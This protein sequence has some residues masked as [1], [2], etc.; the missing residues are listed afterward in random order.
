MKLHINHI[1]LI[2][3]LWGVLFS[4]KREEANLVFLP[5]SSLVIDGKS[6]VNKFNCVYNSKKLNDTLMI[7]YEKK[8]KKYL[9]N[10]AR[11][12]LSNDQFDCGGKGINRDFHKLLRTKEHPFIQMRLKSVF[13]F[14]NKD[15][16]VANI[17]YEIN[18]IKKSYSVPI[19]YSKKLNTIHISGEKKL[20]I[21]DFDLKPPKKLLGIIKV[22]ENIGI[23]FDFIIGE[24]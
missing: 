16:V 21:K 24:K 20:N 15:S 3:T 7:R 4:S 22:K 11:L 8:D 12:N 2:F 17:E 13:L 5:K 10:N 9:F 23:H 19:S 14:D 18:K 6:N 1:V